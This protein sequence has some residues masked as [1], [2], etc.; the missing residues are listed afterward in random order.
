[1]DCRSR[2]RQHKTLHFFTQKTNF[3]RQFSLIF[4]PYHFVP[5]QYASS[6]I[7]PSSSRAFPMKSSRRWLGV[8][9]LACLCLFLAHSVHCFD[10]PQEVR[11]IVAGHKPRSPASLDYS[12]FGGTSCLGDLP[13]RES[14]WIDTY[15]KSA[16][17]LL[18]F[19]ADNRK[20]VDAAHEVIL[21][22]TPSNMEDAEYAAT[23]PG[24]GWMDKHP[25][26]T[27][28]DWIHSI[29]HRDGEG[30]FKGEGNHTG[31]EN[32]KYWAAGGPKALPTGGVPP[33]C[34]HP[35]AVQLASEA[36]QCAPRCCALGLVVVG[37]DKGIPSL[38]AMHSVLADGGIRRTVTVPAG[39]W[40][41]FRF[42]QLLRESPEALR[43]ELEQLCL[44]EYNLLLEYC[45]GNK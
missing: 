41:P 36:P 32:S 40:D 10:L 21:G 31:F 15:G 23:H 22:V 37:R 3:E 35:V 13:P 24:S 39:H 33:I 34:T 38:A 19:L 9:V 28:D 42:V 44:L 8:P 2:I 30:I 16:S 27:V 20:Y 7:S 6:F 25:L 18:L 45:L 26:S 14:D 4:V 1:M 11:D 29:I 5:S 43:D 12:I 17:A